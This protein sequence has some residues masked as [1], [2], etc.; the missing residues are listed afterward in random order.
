MKLLRVG[1][2]GHEHPALLDA[3]GHIRDLSGLIDDIAGEVLTP[4][5]LAKLRAADSAA[6][7]IVDPA[8]RIGPCVGRVGKFVCIGMNYSEHAAEV[9]ATPPDEP[10]VFMKATTAICGPNDPI[11][12]PRN[13]TKLDWE[14]E[15]GVV[16]GREASYVSEAEAADHIAGYCL[17][18]DVSERGFQID[19]GGGQWDKGKGCD[20]FGPIG[21]WL[22]T[23]DEIADVHDLSMQLE[24]NGKRFQDGSTRTMIFRPAFLVSYVSQFMRL[25]PGDILSTGTPSGVGL[26]QHPPVYLQP[27]DEVCL[28]IE[29]LG[30]QRQIVEKAR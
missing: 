7:P 18:N 30:D 29:R 3:E 23:P 9:G 22:V 5:G 11:I 4:E 12:Q 27:G 14:V 16:V 25:Q 13:S 19:R 15:L 17:I 28:R 21:P 1:P 26:A 10:I 6:L 20:S 24:V 2:S 8:T